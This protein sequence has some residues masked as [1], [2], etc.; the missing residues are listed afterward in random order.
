M[1]LEAKQSVCVQCGEFRITEKTGNYDAVDNAGGYGSPNDDFGDTTPYT[2]S[3][4]KPGAST[5][6][7]TLNLLD[8]APAQDSDE[9]YRY[10][11]PPSLLGY[12]SGEPLVSGVWDVEIT[13][14]TDVKGKEILATGDIEA[15]I[16]KCICC[17]G[18]KHAELWLDL[19]TAERLMRCHQ[20]AKAQ[21]VIDQL[22]R[23]TNECCGCS[24]C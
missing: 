20:R 9:F 4:T 17:N 10:T 1:A 15:R 23:D 24:D 2:I 22:Y 13:H 7:Y 18:K 8:N 11:V 16:T 3:F 21:A 12:A 6:A 14:G 19:L 5:P